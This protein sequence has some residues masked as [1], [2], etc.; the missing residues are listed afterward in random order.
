LQRV[1]TTVTLLGLLVATAAAFAITE[2]LKLI[3]SPVFGTLVE[4]PGVL[5]PVCGPDC[6]TRKA[7]VR[8]RLRRTGRVT[9]LIVDSAGHK[10]ATI[11]SNVLVHARSPQHFVW[12]GR[13][14]AGVQ[15][16]DGVYHPWLE[17]PRHTYPFTNKITL[18]S[19]PPKVLSAKRLSGKQDF[20]AGR[21]R[22]VAI[23]Y[24]FSEKAH[25]VVYL[26]RRLIIVGRKTGPIEKLNWAGR[27]GQF[28]KAVPPGTYVLSIGGRDLAGNETPAAERKSV[29]VAVS[30]IEL[31]PERS[32]VRSG[33]R[34]TVHVETAARHYTWRLGKRHGSRRGKTLRLRAPTTPGTY[35]LVVAENGH[36]AAALVQVHGK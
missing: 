3:K 22:S 12:D 29:T 14:D 11:A 26:G 33:R 1:F 31:A 36:A 16:P 19:E 13:T 4:K 35:R 27:L 28:G 10:V 25:A 7:T 5:S 34:F 9:V 23:H 18:D 15:A 20:L 24:S 32:V 8:I 30:Y 17:L 2:H 6:P 21:G